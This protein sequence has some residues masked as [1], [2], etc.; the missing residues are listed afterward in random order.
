[1]VHLWEVSKYSRIALISEC[2]PKRSL[3]ELCHALLAYDRV[4]PWW[5]YMRADNWVDTGLMDL[6]WRVGCFAVFVGV[7]TLDENVARVMNKGISPQQYLD[8]CK[9][10]KQAGIDPYA[11]FI[12]DYVN[13]QKADLEN[14]LSRLQDN[15]AEC[16]GTI[17]AAKLNVDFNSALG[18][19]PKQ[20]NIVPYVS[21]E[22]DW[23]EYDDFH[24]VPYKPFP[25][26]TDM[27]RDWV[28]EFVHKFQATAR[29][30]TQK[31]SKF[32]TT[33]KTEN[34]VW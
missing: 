2:L 23:N 6:M 32:I 25:G 11:G 10:I 29:S 34:V 28:R 1:M 8:R 7:E 20:Y 16:F 12:A 31:Y 4:G 3:E 18:K 22:E 33:A 24:C 30:M 15:M 13:V 26:S 21:P 17:A 27:D 14:S 9:I 5:T 19:N